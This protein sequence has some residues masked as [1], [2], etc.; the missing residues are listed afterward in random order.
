MEQTL[1]V[2]RQAVLA[3]NDG[4]FTMPAGFLG[5][6]EANAALADDD[7]VVRLPIGCFVLPGET[8]EESG[9]EIRHAAVP[10]S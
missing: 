7:G 8:T 6:P 9:R 3:V 2:G 4:L 5:R 1:F 10:H